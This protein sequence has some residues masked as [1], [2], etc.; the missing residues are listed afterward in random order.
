MGKSTVTA[1]GTSGFKLQAVDGQFVVKTYGTY[2]TQ[3]A[4]KRAITT[5]T[6]RARKQHKALPFGSTQNRYVTSRITAVK[7]S[8]KS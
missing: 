5:L 7:A 4:A 6:N 3:E 2:K 8:K 1:T